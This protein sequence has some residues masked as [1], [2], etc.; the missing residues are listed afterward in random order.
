[1]LQVTNYIYSHWEMYKI[2]RYCLNYSGTSGFCPLKSK[3][4]IMPFSDDIRLNTLFLRH[5]DPAY[6]TS[7]DVLQNS[8]FLVFFNT[9]N[10]NN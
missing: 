7:F 10:P 5:M 8:V 3:T 2:M 4:K 1:M 9:L 6:F